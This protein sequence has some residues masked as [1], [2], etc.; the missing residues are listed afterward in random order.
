MKAHAMRDFVSLVLVLCFVASSL[1]SPSWAITGAHSPRARRLSSSRRAREPMVETSRRG[2]ALPRAYPDSLIDPAYRLRAAAQLE[3]MRDSLH[4]YIPP[5]GYVPAGPMGNSSCTWRSIGPT[6]VNGRITGIAIDPTDRNRIIVSTVGGIWRSTDQG[7]TWRRVSD[8]A[9]PSSTQPLKAGIFGAV[10]INPALPNEVIVGGG[11]PNAFDHYDEGPAG[12]PGLWRSTS[13]GD[14]GTFGYEGQTSLDAA[15]IERIRIGPTTQNNDVYVATS[16]GVWKGIHTPSGAIQWSQIG[17]DACSDLVVDYSQ[18]PPVVIAGIYGPAT[19]KGIKRYKDG[20]WSPVWNGTTENSGAIS[21]AMSPSD[22]SRLYAK[23][24]DAT[25]GGL[26]GIYVSRDGGSTW[27]RRNSSSDVDDSYDYT[28]YNGAIEVAPNDPDKVYVGGIDLY[29]ATRGGLTPIAGTTAW[30]ENGGQA[31][32]DLSDSSSPNDRPANN[33]HDHHAIAFDPTDPNILWVGN[34]G[35]LLYAENTNTSSWHWSERSHGMTITQFYALATQGGTLSAVAGG[36]QDNGT[37]VTFGNRTWYPFPSC[38]AYSVSLDAPTS[39]ALFQGCLEEVVEMVN[40]VAGTADGGKTLSWAPGSDLPLPPVASDPTGEGQAL[41]SRQ[42]ASPNTPP[43]P[44]RVLKTTAGQSWAPASDE[45][46]ADSRITS[47]AIGATCI[48][49]TLTHFCSFYVGFVDTLTGA[50]AIWSSSDA[51]VSWTKT[52]AGLPAGLSPNAIAVDRTNSSHAFAGFGGKRGGSGAILVTFDHGATW[53]SLVASGTSLPDG[54]IVAVAIDPSDPAVIYVSNGSGFFRGDVPVM[55][56]SV[57]WTPFDEGLPRA[58]DVTAIAV[59]QQEKKLVVSTMG[60]G[61]YER[62][63]DPAAAC[64]EVVLSIRDNVFDTGVGPSPTDQ[65]DPEHPVSDPGRPAG[66]FEQSPDLVHWWS[67]P[68]IRIEVPGRDPPRNQVPADRVDP[69]A[70]E[71]CPIDATLC[72]AGSMNCPECP[73]GT[74]F[75]QDPHAGELARVWVQVTNRGARVA[76]D[77]RVVALWA[78]ATAG[79]PLLPSDFW[80]TAL[81]AASG[82][83]TVPTAPSE[84]HLLPGGNSSDCSKRIPMLEGGQAQVV[85]FDWQVPMDAAAHSCMLAMVESPDDPIDPS[86]RTVPVL[87][88]DDF[89][90]ANHQIGLRNLH[91]VDG[92]QATHIVTGTEALSITNPTADTSAIELDIYRPGMRPTSKI[93]LRFPTLSNAPSLLNVI[94]VHDPLSPS[95]RI[96]AVNLDVDT[97]RTFRTAGPVATIKGLHI[98]PGAT[99]RVQLDY[100]AQGPPNTAPRFTVLTRRGSKVFG[101]STYVLRVR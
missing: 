20:A 80:N 32:K 58:V 66:F 25:S 6:N 64:P 16:I 23:I 40:P 70:M 96:L 21:L 53:T 35:G 8:M 94:V 45:L 49:S 79:L 76:R 13:Q 83:C 92:T 14:P 101:G 97:T 68:D 43:I 95:E 69:V 51:G 71:T 86:L 93:D 41:S 62:D 98:P 33:R 61:A 22:P 91:V 85:E 3:A 39:S 30:T 18:S 1:V 7:G 72:P 82:P 31:W 87:R 5:P 75:D 11:D 65:P 57:R 77:L 74:L 44:L 2:Y 89:I 50:P 9:S 100:D 17:T 24:E 84:W 37:L 81:P 46:P 10:A 42:P 59:N 38:D 52:T 34:D 56:T 99:W 12:G 28:W 47:I 4:P 54:P 73:N 55:S 48:Q 15:V 78:D 19:E 36:S 67:S 90:Q 26:E 63:V 29:R 60:Y 88:P 27:V